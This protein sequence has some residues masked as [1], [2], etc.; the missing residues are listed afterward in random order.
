MLPPAPTCRRA[1]QRQLHTPSDSIWISDEAL[2][3]VFQ[4]FCAVS[5]TRKRY[6]SFVPGPLENRRRLGKRRM[7]LQSNAAPTPV[8]GVADISR[9]LFGEVD[10]TRWQWQAPTSRDTRTEEAPVGS[11]ERLGKWATSLE[12]PSALPNWLVEW[13]TPSQALPESPTDSISRSKGRVDAIPFRDEIR[14]FTA[15]IK[16]CSHEDRP[17]LCDGF[18]Q[19]LTEALF[20]SKHAEDI[21]LYTM[22]TV[23]PNLEGACSDSNEAS[24]RCL[25][26]SQA[27]WNGISSSKVLHPSDFQ[28]RTM[29]RFASILCQINM[30]EAL[31]SLASDVLSSVSEAQLLV[32]H[33][34]IAR[35]VNSWVLTWQERPSLDFDETGPA[36]A[37][38]EDSVFEATH[39]VSSVGDF[40][41][42]LEHNRCIED[43]ARGFRKALQVA[44]QAIISSANCIREA[45]HKIRPHQRS[46]RALAA[47]LGGLPPGI[48]RTIVHQCSSRIPAPSEN[49][50][51][52]SLVTM[53]W[54]WLSVVFQ[55]PNVKEEFLLET[56]QQY[57]AYLS[58]A[59][60]SDILFD[61]WMSRDLFARPALTRIVFDVTFAESRHRRFGLLLRVIHGER[62]K[63]W[64]KMRLLFGFLDKLGQ[65]ET[66][67][68]TLAALNKAA[69]KM[70]AD[71]IDE[72]L[73]KMAVADPQ[74]A[75]KTFRTYMP[76]QYNE[77]PL[78]LETCPNFIFTM[79]ENESVKTRTI[80]DSLGIPIYE[81][82]SQRDLANFSNLAN[83]RIVESL[84]PAEVE[85]FTKMATLFAHCKVRTHRVAF[86]NVMQCLFH[87]RRYRAPITPEFS[88]ALVHVAIAR[89]IECDGWIAKER[90]A[91]ILSLVEGA[92]G[93]KVAMD[94][95]EVVAAWNQLISVRV[96]ERD[97]RM[98]RTGIRHA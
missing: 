77:A 12:T 50:Q 81:T 54:K 41:A 88:R 84:S 56:W 40:T 44:K 11:L 10:R 68:K 18:N 37:L 66:I 95:D 2:S 43:D 20:L 91:W 55:L 7:T 64:E 71:I 21:F 92:E 89:K 8:S 94:V 28:S 26:L 13:G 32:M 48:V 1:L 86:R 63:S 75:L 34:S 29:G 3:V 23:F 24:Q 39:A 42:L 67:Y 59:E 27:M 5:K 25:A 76:M 85:H 22:Q 47:V 30:S 60:A 97:R 82:L 57:G 45:Q 83:N 38:A 6:G 69:F 93:T 96:S 19:K 90:H 53:Q 35:L 61:H 74:L 31:Q 62:E 87:L 16:T 36:L 78:R 52:N 46:I 4:R 72:T 15:A 17:S 65:H 80:W 51:G 49:T 33:P 14:S 79:I 9:F 73:E 98:N 70:P 58:Q